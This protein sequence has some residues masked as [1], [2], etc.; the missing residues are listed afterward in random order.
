MSSPEYDVVVL[1]GG[2]HGVGVAQAAA[3]AGHRTLLLEKSALAAGTSSKSSKLIHGGLRYLESWEFGLVRESLRE[4]RT[5]LRI[6]PDLVKLIPF[7]LPIYKRTSRSAL[8]VRAG[9]SLYAL[10]G[11]M[12]REAQFES[13]DRARWQDLDGL[14][15]DGLERVFRYYD[16]QTDDAQLVRAVMASAQEL[17][18]EL[19]CPATFSRAWRTDYGYLGRYELSGEEREFSTRVLVNAAGPW[20]EEVRATVEP[21]PPGLA[22]ELVQGAHIEVP[23]KLERGAYYTEAPRDRRAVFTLP[24]KGHTLVGTT[25]TPF[26]AE[27][28]RSAPTAEEVRYLQEVFRGHFPARDATVLQAWSGLRVLPAAEGSA[29]GRTR[30]TLLRVDD[31][32]IPRYL[33]IYGGK[34]TGYRAAAEKVMQRLRASLPPREALART[35]ELSLRPVRD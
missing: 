21:L 29:F 19:A 17:G 24:W 26:S 32:T 6:A 7:H 13:L 16:A 34:L 15:T 20:I 27:P 23:G 10:L 28:E 8:E 30:E 3:A 9:L 31:P 4:R 2:I 35:D 33:A 11:G 5:L 25:E 18:A 1:G 14:R 22:I 12:D